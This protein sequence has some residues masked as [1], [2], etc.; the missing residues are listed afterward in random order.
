MDCDWP[1]G[2]CLWDCGWPTV[3]G[4]FEIAG[5]D[6]ADGRERLQHH[7]AA[8]NYDPQSPSKCDSGANPSDF[9]PNDTNLR[10]GQCI[11]TNRSLNRNN[12]SSYSNAIGVRVRRF[13]LNTRFTA[14]G[15]L[16]RQRKEALINASNAKEKAQHRP[17]KYQA[18]DQ[19]LDQ[20]S[21]E[22]PKPTKYGGPP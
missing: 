1:N 7:Q 16:I 18:D 15:A 20:V 10:G 11:T 8:T 13:L 12:N 6:S 17:H 5:F 22:L 14:S 4:W 3:T 2:P 21:E 9:G 19:V